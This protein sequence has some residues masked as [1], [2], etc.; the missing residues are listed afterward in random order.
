[1]SCGGGIQSTRVRITHST[2]R[3]LDDGTIDPAADARK[4]L[5]LC[6]TAASLKQSKD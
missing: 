2:A 5:G 1:M 3:L 4:I 6:N